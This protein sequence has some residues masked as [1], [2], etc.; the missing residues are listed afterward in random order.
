MRP[1]LRQLLASWGVSNFSSSKKTEDGGRTDGY[2][3]Q[4]GRRGAPSAKRHS[5]K[6]ITKATFRPDDDEVYLTT[7]ISRAD[8]VAH[9]EGI[10]RPNKAGVT[11]SIAMNITV[12]QSWIHK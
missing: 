8:S 3:T 1:A 5:Y 11:E 9:D 7:D 2:T 10:S 4:S 12:Q 6:N